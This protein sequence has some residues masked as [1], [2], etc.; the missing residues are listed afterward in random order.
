MITQAAYRRP[1]SHGAWS[2]VARKIGATSPIPS[3]T[4]MLERDTIYEFALR[5]RSSVARSA[6]STSS[7]TLLT[8]SSLRMVKVLVPETVR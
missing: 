3:I 6:L 4:S 5:T 1:R 2:I 7:R 8:K